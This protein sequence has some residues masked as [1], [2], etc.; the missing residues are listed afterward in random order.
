VYPSPYSPL[1]D[2]MNALQIE[3]RPREEL[4]AG[5]REKKKFWDMGWAGKKDKDKTKNSEARYD[6][7]RRS[8]DIWSREVENVPPQ[9]F[10][11]ERGRAY[12][13]GRIDDRSRVLAVEPEQNNAAA[14]RDVQTAIRESAP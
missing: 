4:D 11:E 3:Q 14:A 12:E 1:S 5:P 9:S 8:V 6:D 13:R 7:G 2:E 10:E